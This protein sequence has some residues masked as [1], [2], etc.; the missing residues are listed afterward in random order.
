M[1][2]EHIEPAG[3]DQL[4]NLCLSCPSCNLS[5]G[6]VTTSNDPETGEIVSLFNPRTQ[7]WSEHF[8]WIE[9]GARILGKTPIGRATIERLKMNIERVITSRQV[10]IKAGAHPPK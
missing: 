1:H 9:D 8:E 5:K 2:V 3:G 7:L 10:W 4:D 6:K